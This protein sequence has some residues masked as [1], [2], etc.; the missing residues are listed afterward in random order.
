VCVFLFFRFR[1]ANRLKEQGKLIELREYDVSHVGAVPTI[2]KGGSA[3]G[4]DVHAASVLKEY[5]NK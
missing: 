4:A 1:Y 2:A 5:L 3:E